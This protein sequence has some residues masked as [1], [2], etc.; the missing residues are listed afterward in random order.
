[1]GPAKG[2]QTFMESVLERGSEVGRGAVL[3]SATEVQPPQETGILEPETH[4]GF[5]QIP[6][7]KA[8]PLETVVMAA[9]ARGC[10][11]S[12]FACLAAQPA[13]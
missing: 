3:I 2:N 10:L 8:T 12:P 4:P 5:P 7:R 9:A 11:P 1:M 13:C 6:Q